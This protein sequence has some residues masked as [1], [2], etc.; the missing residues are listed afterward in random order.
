MLKGINKALNNSNLCSERIF[1]FLPDS[2]VAVV[3]FKT[4]VFEKQSYSD[5]FCAPLKNKTLEDILFT[6]FV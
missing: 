4:R 3:P 6:K 1:W 2:C 5:Y